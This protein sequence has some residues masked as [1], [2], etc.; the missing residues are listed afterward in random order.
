MCTCCHAQ[1]PDHHASFCRWP[2][3]G[4][5]HALCAGLPTVGG[6]RR[7]SCWVRLRLAEQGRRVLAPRLTI[8]GFFSPARRRLLRGGL[9]AVPGHPHDHHPGRAPG[10]PAEQGGAGTPRCARWHQPNLQPTTQTPANLPW[11]PVQFCTNIGFWIVLN[12]NWSYD[13]ADLAPKAGHPGPAAAAA[14][15]LAAAVPAASRD[16]GAHVPGSSTPPRAEGRA[17]AS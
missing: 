5:G 13:N 7:A 2:V 17:A 8:T 10:A 4:L 14:L 6:Q 16:E 11:L 15:Q 9:R 12:R 1:L 3:R